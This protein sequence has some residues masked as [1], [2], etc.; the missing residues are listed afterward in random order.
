MVAVLTIVV[1]FAALAVSVYALV[2]ASRTDRRDLFLQM[3]HLLT[4]QDL[5][6][7]RR[8]LF[9]K[10]KTINDVRLIRKDDETG[11]ALINRALAMFELLAF[12]VD[13]GYIDKDLMLQ[14]WGHT[15]ARAWSHG[16]HFVAERLEREQDGWS[17]WPHLQT[18][19]PE[20]QVWAVQHP[21][22]LLQNTDLQY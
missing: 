2:T 15:Y 12:Y 13:R 5:Q 10:V 8:L 16:R 22:R 20:A 9:E 14:E 17:G 1:S 6:E 18:L 19:G 11:A 7:G 21:P 3:H 4:D